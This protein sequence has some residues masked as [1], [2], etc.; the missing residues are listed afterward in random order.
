M[1][2][3]VLADGFESGSL[4][5]WSVTMEGDARVGVEWPAAYRGN[6]AGRF[7]VSATSTS[8]ANI[9]RSLPQGAKVA[10]AD[11]WFRVDGEGK[12]GSNV[13]F[14]RF[15]DGSARIADVYRQNSTGGAWFRSRDA[16]GAFVFTPLGIDLALGRWYHVRLHVRANGSTSTVQ[17]WIDDVVRYS[18]SSFWLPTSRLTA[19]L[20]GSEHVSQQMDLRFDDVVLEGS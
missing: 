15:F 19:I 7:Q 1:Q 3:L 16:N 20:L 14:F 8:R 18:S 2:P 6:C 11:G 17:V 5:S 12:S 10:I 13:G 9:T 4:S